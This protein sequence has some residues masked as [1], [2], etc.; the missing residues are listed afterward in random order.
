MEKV[1]II[2]SSKEYFQDLLV[3]LNSIDKL[4]RKGK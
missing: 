1:Q 4:K 2:C 3:P